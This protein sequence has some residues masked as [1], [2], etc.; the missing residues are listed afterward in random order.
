MTSAHLALEAVALYAGLPLLFDRLIARGHR[1]MLFPGLWTLAAI[2]ALVLRADP[3]FDDARLWSVHIDPLY[4]RVLVARTIVGIGVVAVLTRRLSPGAWLVLPRTRPRLWLL[5]ATL[6]PVLSVLPQGVFWRVFFVHRYEPLLGHGATMLVAGTIAFAFAHVIFR[7]AVAVALTA[8]GGFLF[9]HTYLATG[10][11]LVS[12]LE[13]AAYGV[14]AFTFGIGRSLYLG[15][16]RAMPAA[17]QPP[18][19]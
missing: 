5:V 12:S 13:H 1:W 6:Y 14:A 7:N 9:M 17:A 10:S 15:S 2:A 8:L 11:M 19:Q 3:A 4:A 16:T 18:A